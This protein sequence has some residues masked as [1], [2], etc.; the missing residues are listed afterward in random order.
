MEYKYE[1]L[2]IWKLSKWL[3]YRKDNIK[4]TLV[5]SYEQG[6]DFNNDY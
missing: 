6:V 3:E 5:K 1:Q 2:I 4:K